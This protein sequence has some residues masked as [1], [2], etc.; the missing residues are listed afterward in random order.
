V[1]RSHIKIGKFNSAQCYH[2]IIKFYHDA[3]T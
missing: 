3:H 2:E 1:R